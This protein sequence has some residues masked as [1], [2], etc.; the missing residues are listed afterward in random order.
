MRTAFTCPHC[1]AAVKQDPWKLLASAP[2]TCENCGT[3]YKAVFSERSTFIALVVGA[4]VWF[5]AFL[6]VN[7]AGYREISE[8]VA[9]AVAI[10]GV[11]V[12]SYRYAVSFEVAK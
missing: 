5:V 3:R 9:S 2:A 1:R 8:A 6:L 4:A 11:A 12:C 7:A 10:L